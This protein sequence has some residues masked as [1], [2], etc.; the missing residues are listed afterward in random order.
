M[1]HDLDDLTLILEYFSWL[2]YTQLFSDV[3]FIVGTS[4]SLS[5]KAPARWMCCVKLCTIGARSDGE[6]GAAG[7]PDFLQSTAYFPRS[8][9]RQTL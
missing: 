9:P 5:N 2:Q 6:G 7:E 3:S 4:N 1:H 8:S